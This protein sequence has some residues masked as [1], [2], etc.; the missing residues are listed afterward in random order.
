MFGSKKKEQD[1]SKMLHTLWAKKKQSIRKVETNQKIQKK[2]TK[3]SLEVEKKTT[4]ANQIH[5]KKIFY[6]PNYR[7]LNMDY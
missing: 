4:V 5:K 7:G 6:I 2:N 1:I 3:I